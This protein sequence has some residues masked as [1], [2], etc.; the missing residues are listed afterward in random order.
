MPA[1][2]QPP[3]DDGHHHLNAWT[4]ITVFLALAA[5]VS[6]LAAVWPARRAAKLDILDSIKAE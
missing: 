5:S 6:I 1:P 3:P 4:R 2:V